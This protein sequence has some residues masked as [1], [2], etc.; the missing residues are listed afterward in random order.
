MDTLC[1]RPIHAKHTFRRWNRQYQD[2]I[3]GGLSDS[4][5]SM[6]FSLV[7]VFKGVHLKELCTVD[8]ATVESIIN[9]IN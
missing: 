7:S 6:M 9:K 3:A 4:N 1:Y 5:I 2:E 8:V